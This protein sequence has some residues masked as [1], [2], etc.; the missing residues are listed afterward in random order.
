[1]ALKHLI[2]LSAATGEA[3]EQELASILDASVRNNKPKNV[4]GVLLFTKGHFMQALEGDEQDLAEIYARIEKDPRHTDLVV[5]AHEHI[6]KRNF[7]QWNM[8][9]RQLNDSDALA[10]PAWAP[11][12]AD[13]FDAT[14]IGAKPGTALSML[15]LFAQT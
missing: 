14:V 12:F 10:N 13:G 15:K 11:F 3:G 1:M 6:V 5:L 8:G 4:T 9:Y 2:Y 7:S